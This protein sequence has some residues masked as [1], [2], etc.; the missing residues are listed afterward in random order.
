MASARSTATD[1]TRSR[2]GAVAH[3][4]RH[5]VPDHVPGGR[6]VEGEPLP[7]LVGGL[8]LP[9]NC[10]FVR[11]VGLPVSS[12]S[13]WRSAPRRR[14]RS[15]V[16]LVTVIQYVAYSASARSTWDLHVI[17]GAPGAHRP[18]ASPSRPRATGAGQRNVNQR[19]V[20]CGVRLPVKWVPLTGARSSSRRPGSPTRPGSGC[21]PAA[22]ERAGG[23]PG[24][25]RTR[26]AA[27][28]ERRPGRA[29]VEALVEA[30]VA[31]TQTRLRSRSSTATAFTGRLGSPAVRFV[32]WDP[33]VVGDEDPPSADRAA[34]GD[35]PPGAARL[36]E[37]VAD[38]GPRPRCRERGERRPGRAE[39][40]AQHPT[41][42][43]PDD[44]GVRVGD[45]HR[46]GGPG[47]RVAQP[48]PRAA[49][50]AR[51]VERLHADRRGVAVV[52]LLSTGG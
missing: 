43:E 48:G 47:G 1:P 41:V 28:R 45:V 4:G 22:P 50:V 31:A 12:G 29:G 14:R 2:G 6:P 3:G 42:G 39:P 18:S 23:R 51:H 26:S 10:T 13:G 21:G 17:C 15:A 44:H 36:G 37:Q 33:A 8:A 16:R 46:G 27:R 24:R 52:A 38:L 5:H 9:V 34:G 30:E 35:Q 49:V 11:M 40:G 7:R 25:R 32:Q 20:S 19:R